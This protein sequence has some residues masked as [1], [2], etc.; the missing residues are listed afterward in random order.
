MSLDQM[1][2]A[3]RSH[4]L[5]V[6]IHHAADTGIDEFRESVRDAMSAEG[7]YVIINFLRA[8]I[9]QETGGHFSPL[10]AY[11]ADDR[12][13][14]LDTSKYKYPPVWV[15]VPEMWEAMQAGDS[16]SGISRGYLVVSV[17]KKVSN[18]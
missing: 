15:T 9:G 18:E 12:C 2:E 17:S 10:G 3:M 7:R 11:S 8:A 6:T 13:L 16:A 4:G 14:H 1:G 5:D